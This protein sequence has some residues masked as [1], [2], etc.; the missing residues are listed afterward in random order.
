[1]FFFNSA[2]KNKP[3]RY[4]SVKEKT[5]ADDIAKPSKK[6][7]RLFEQ[8]GSKPIWSRRVRDMRWAERQRLHMLTDAPFRDEALF[9][10]ALIQFDGENTAS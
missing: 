9:S 6:T 8:N 3:Y 2:F 10:M 1:M 4:N 7:L 5:H